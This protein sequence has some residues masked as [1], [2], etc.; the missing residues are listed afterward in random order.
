MKEW[1]ANTIGTVYPV[2]YTILY[3]IT[4]HRV[5]V[6]KI[7]D[8]DVFNPEERKLWVTISDNAIKMAA[9]DWCKIFGSDNNEIHY[10]KYVD[11]ESFLRRL[12]SIDYEKVEKEMR[13]FRNRFV[14]HSGKYD[15]PVPIFDDAIRIISF[16]QEEVETE[17]DLH[18]CSLDKIDGKMESYQI[19]IEDYLE[20]HNIDFE[21]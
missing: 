20:M 7:K 3:N 9:L 2:I 8:N 18:G 4:L 5:I 17:Y 6:H 13:F 16:F 21:P 19:Q 14:A 1:D 11:K 15:I 12:I 10:S